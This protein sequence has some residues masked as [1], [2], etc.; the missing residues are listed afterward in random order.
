MIAA[1]IIT[2]LALLAAHGVTIW[3]Y[4]EIVKGLRDQNSEL[5]DRWNIAR[6]LPPQGVDTKSVYE[7]REEKR[8]ATKKLALPRA[9]P[10]T[11]ARH[12]LFADEM[13]A[14]LKSAAEV[15]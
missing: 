1:F 14:H 15:N 2:I 3:A 13:D 5:F 11:H 8:E 10:L 6:G 7:K 9:D 4:R 12:E